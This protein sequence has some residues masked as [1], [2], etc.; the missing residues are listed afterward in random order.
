M[1]E[2]MQARIKRDKQRETMSTGRSSRNDRAR[3]KSTVTS[4]RETWEE[5]GVA[6]ERTKILQEM[7]K[8][9]AA[10]NLARNAAQAAF[11]SNS[12]SAVETSEEPPI[13]LLLPL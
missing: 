11:E 8:A 12:T 5:E 10:R 9:R 2:R 4:E 7:A 6:V 13:L 3:K 1:F